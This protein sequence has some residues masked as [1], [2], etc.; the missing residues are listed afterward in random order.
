LP[1]EAGE[2][3]VVRDGRE[4]HH[5]RALTWPDTND[6]VARAGIAMM[7]DWSYDLFVTDLGVPVELEFSASASATE[8]GRT[9]E[10]QVDAT[11]K[12]SRFSK[13]IA[14]TAPEM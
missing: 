6:P 8:N 14:V 12:I 7:R 11:V 5:L 9:T 3:L 2:G 1:D 10:I 4:L 13:P